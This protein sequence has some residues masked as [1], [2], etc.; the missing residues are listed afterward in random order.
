[1][2]EQR[3]EQYR[4]T[5]EDTIAA[6]RARQ[7]DTMGRLEYEMAHRAQ[8]QRLIE[9]LRAEL[10]DLAVALER[11]RRVSRYLAEAYAS[12]FLAN[13]YV[14]KAALDA[15]SEPDL[16][17]MDDVGTDWYLAQQAVDDGREGE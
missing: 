17:V 5:A 6:L 3:D 16:D 8:T 10:H 13:N 4:D 2:D 9:Q 12:D 7:A 15:T 14:I 1:M 11:A